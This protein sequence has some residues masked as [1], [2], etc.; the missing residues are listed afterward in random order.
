MKKPKKPKVKS[1][2]A[3]QKKQIGTY[4]RC[5][6]SH[7]KS[8]EVAAANKYSRTAAARP[9]NGEAT[10]TLVSDEACSRCGGRLDRAEATQGAV[11]G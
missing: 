5:R 6:K 2:S 11:G 7:T 4:R 9:T 1:F 10:E 8:R 3:I